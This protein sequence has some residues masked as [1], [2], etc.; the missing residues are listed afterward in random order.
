MMKV[1]YQEISHFLEEKREKNF[2][3]NFTQKNLFSSSQKIFF[4]Q[5]LPFFLFCLLF[6]KEKDHIGQTCRI[7]LSA[8][9]DRI[10]T[11]I[12]LVD[13]HGHADHLLENWS[14]FC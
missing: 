12:S 4:Q 10:A 2:I 6:S 7:G 13:V 9:L 1:F 5:N 3:R 14:N 8:N 11:L